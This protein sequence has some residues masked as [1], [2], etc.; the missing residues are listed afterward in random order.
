MTNLLTVLPE[1]NVQPY[2]HI[3]PSLEKALVSI[4]DLLTLDAFDV[5]KRAQVPPAEVKKL[6][7]RILEELQAS[8]YRGEDN[9]TND[10]PDSATPGRISALDDGIDDALTGGIATG[11]LTEFVGER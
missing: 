3:L 9:E 4:A 6:A 2:T 11:T 5:A 8:T 10:R 1:F 7:E